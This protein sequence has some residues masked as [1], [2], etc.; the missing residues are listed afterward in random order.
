MS[1]HTSKLVRAMKGWNEALRSY[2]DPPKGVFG[3]R[4]II[5]SWAVTLDSDELDFEFEA[6]C[7]SDLEAN[8][9]NI[10]VY[11][12]TQ[13]TIKNLMVGKPITITS[14]Y[15][16]DTGVICRG[17]ITKVKTK[18]EGVDKVTNIHALDSMGLE[19]KDIANVTYAAGT[20]ASYILK[21]LINKTHLP[22]AVFAPRRNW[23]HEDEVAISGGLME[24]IR[25]YSEICGIS[26]FINQG[27]VYAMELSK[28]ANG[29][30]NLNVD[31]GLIGSPEESQETIQAEGYEDTITVINAK[32]LLQ[33]RLTT[34]AVVNLQ[35][36]NFSGEYRA[37]AVKH[38]FNPDEAYSE[39]ELV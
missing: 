14:G 27:K 13:N 1:N 39:V 4:A 19:E 26:T 29:Y 18:K 31:T 35:S 30:F 23:T 24:S 32:C 16:G 11:N 34:G 3:R 36:Q 8:E 15:K 2:T 20:T 7:D 37:R 12:L 21:D 33:H 28:G 10:T 17:I 5:E 6:S 22:I 38:I 9:I 25:E